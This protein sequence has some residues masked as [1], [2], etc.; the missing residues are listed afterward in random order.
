MTQRPLPMTLPDIPPAAKALKR[1]FWR[2]ACRYGFSLPAEAMIAA[3]KGLFD[4]QYNIQR[5][6]VGE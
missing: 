5:A 2:A 3:L 1:S 4:Q 6:Q